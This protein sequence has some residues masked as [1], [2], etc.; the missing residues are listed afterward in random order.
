MI[1]NR[2]HNNHKLLKF[3]TNCVFFV[4]IRTENIHQTIIYNDNYQS[5]KCKEKNGFSNTKVECKFLKLNISSSLQIAWKSVRMTTTLSADLTGIPI[6]TYATSN[7]T[8]AE[9]PQSSLCTEEFAVNI[10]PYKKTIKVLKKEQI[11]NLFTR[12]QSICYS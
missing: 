5:I 12:I 2:Q 4:L 3:N 9:T 11:I 7:T 1:I 6:R 10:F 8:H